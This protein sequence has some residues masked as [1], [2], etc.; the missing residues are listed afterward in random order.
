[1]PREVVKYMIHGLLASVVLSAAEAVPANG[2]DRPADY[3][4][5]AA[6]PW[7]V[8]PWAGR[9]F[10]FWPYPHKD[11]RESAS[12][13][14]YLHE[15]EAQK[16]VTP[17]WD[18]ADYRWPA[19]SDA[20]EW[21]YSV[22]ALGGNRDRLRELAR[23]DRR[24]CYEQ[25]KA[26]IQERTGR[27]RNSTTPIPEGLPILTLTGF[28]WW[29]VYGAQWGSDLLG[30]EIG[31]VFGASSKWAFARGAARQNKI[32]LLA[33][34]SPWGY[35]GLNSFKAG[36]DEY[37]PAGPNDPS[38]AEALGGGENR[39]HWHAGIP[40]SSHS[41]LWYLS[42]LSGA[43]VVV[44]EANSLNF[45]AWDETKGKEYYLEQI[46]PFVPRDESERAIL[47]PIGRRARDFMRVTT[48]HP[49]RGIPY[50]PI[51]IVLDEYCGFNG[52][53]R[54][55]PRPWHVLPPTL[56][57]RE[58]ELFL[59]VLFPGSV[60]MNHVLL[61]N[62]LNTARQ[63]PPTV[64]HPPFGNSFDVLLSNA[65][66][67]ILAS[68]SALVL[69]GDHEMSAAF[70]ERLEGYL[71]QGGRVCLTHAQAETFGSRM[72][73]LE[74]AGTVEIYGL[75]ETERPTAAEPEYWAL[76]VP[77]HRFRKPILPDDVEEL[78]RLQAEGLGT[79][80][81]YEQAYQREVAGVMTRLGAALLPI[82]VNGDIEY[83]V[84]RT[85]TGWVVGL[86]NNDGVAKS[87]R[88]PVILDRTKT[89]QVTVRPRHTSRAASA[90]EWV[91]E[92]PLAIKDG[93]VRVTVPPGEV[94]IV[95]FI[96]EVEPQ[97]KTA[98]IADERR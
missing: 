52:F 96:E 35:G 55:R 53:L 30:I 17:V 67:G 89:R 27:Y 63:L 28:S 15:C 54:T 38:S 73:Q 50:T 58:T 49:G 92:Q 10:A 37:T 7:Q 66:P 46:A 8:R 16:L 98:D 62:M 18:I 42:W 70:V 68:Y 36:L 33:D 41:R 83:I 39:N 84:N 2:I 1:M 93:G 64:E 87:Y 3:D 47:S 88:S 31:N 45:F 74:S 82:E 75:K 51:A 61:T 5:L 78:N 69:V 56:G 91:M 20:M 11:L 21:G 57:D 97:T 77:F 4:Q 79:L 19:S 13:R 6:G 12:Y 14:R 44:P 22:Y 94:R 95:E 26:W 24:T 71:R 90:S 25:Y 40:P 60:P 76:Q 48:R 29:S 81:P 72:A 85:R 9:E 23:T 59:D 34:I 43:S 86:I 80:R 65:D 32:P